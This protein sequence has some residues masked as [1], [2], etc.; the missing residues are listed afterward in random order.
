MWKCLCILNFFLYALS[1]HA[2]AGTLDILSRCALLVF[3]S[4]HGKVIQYENKGEKR[5]VAMKRR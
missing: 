1:F 2:R 3:R 4:A 5:N